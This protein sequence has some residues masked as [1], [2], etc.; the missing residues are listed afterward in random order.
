[1][2]AINLPCKVWFDSNVSACDML[3]INPLNQ[4]TPSP[5]SI[6]T[7]YF[8]TGIW[9]C[10]SVSSLFSL[11][12]AASKEPPGKSQSLSLRCQKY[13]LNGTSTDLGLKT[14]F[15]S[16]RFTLLSCVL[17]WGASSSDLVFCA[18]A[19]RTSSCIYSFCYPRYWAIEMNSLQ[20]SATQET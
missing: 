5:P 11:L 4:N 8:R 14:K 13:L 19:G 20:H 3:K 15:S 10:L 9:K 17:I 1:M 2:V 6:C 12:L 18:T 7:N 16:L